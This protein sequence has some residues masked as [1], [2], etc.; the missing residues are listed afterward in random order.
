MYNIPPKQKFMISDGRASKLRVSGR[1]DKMISQM[2]VSTGKL[3][4]ITQKR[5]QLIS[6]AQRIWSEFYT[7]FADFRITWIHRWY[8]VHYLKWDPNSMFHRL[9]L[10]V[11][12]LNHNWCL[13]EVDNILKYS[14]RFWTVD[15]C[16]AA[17]HG[18]PTSIR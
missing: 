11:R 16:S 4:P 17:L 5:N 8:W 14:K 7:H 2:K 18:L 9:I 1:S 12:M 3:S 6:T 15:C 13:L 10:T